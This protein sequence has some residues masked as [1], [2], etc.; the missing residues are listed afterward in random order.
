[1][2][3]SANTFSHVSFKAAVRILTRFAICHA[4]AM[5]H[6]Q[7]EMSPFTGKKMKIFTHLLNLTLFIWLV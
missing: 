7:G 6:A 4:V 1:M 5:I 2:K 3:K